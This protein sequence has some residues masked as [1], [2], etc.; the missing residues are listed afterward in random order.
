MLVWGTSNRTGTWS[1]RI[2]SST[3]SANVRSASCAACSHFLLL[4]PLA[5]TAVTG[6][7]GSANGAGSANYCTAGYR[8]LLPLAVTAVTDRPTPLNPVSNPRGL[9]QWLLRPLLFASQF[10]TVVSTAGKI[11][12]TDVGHA[13]AIASLLALEG[14]RH[15]SHCSFQQTGN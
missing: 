15:N 4:L 13:L 1:R 2:C 8:Y 5:A 14:S 6:S 10:S 9:V 7:A 12:E 11:D 3:C